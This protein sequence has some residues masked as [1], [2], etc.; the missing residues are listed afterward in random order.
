M[1]RSRAT[2]VLGACALGGA[3]AL[4]LNIN[5]HPPIADAAETPGLLELAASLAAMA[6]P[7]VALST[8][9]IAWHGVA[10][11][12]A[13]ML[14]ALAVWRFSRSLP[15][16]AAMGVVAAASPL[17]F[18]SLA[19]PDVM[20]IA[21][22]AATACAIL[23][24]GII[25]PIAG[26]MAVGAIAPSLI[27]PNAI[28]CWW[29]TRRTAGR[30]RE[31][32]SFAAGSACF[33]AGSA[34]V[35]ANPSLPGQ[36][37]TLAGLRVMMPSGALAA[38]ALSLTTSVVVGMGP[39]A[40]ALAALGLFVS[41]SEA[42]QSAAPDRTR[43]A[44]PTIGFLAGACAAALG[45][46]ADPIRTFAPFVVAAWILMGRGLAEILR[47]SAG[48]WRSVGGIAIAAI[49]V[50]INVSPRVHR[51]P[52]ASDAPVPLGHDTLT[53]R[54][55][56]ELLYQLPPGSAL[57]S[58][59]AISDILLRSLST[60]LRRSRN[61]ISVVPRTS[62]AVGIARANERVFALPRAQTELQQR[63]VRFVEGLV[64][65]VPGVAEVAALAPCDLL[66][67]TWQTLAAAA[68][69][70]RLAI[71]AGN[72]DAR[73]PVVIFTGGPRAID[74]TA[75]GWPALALRGF[76]TRSYDRARPE[77]KQGLLDELI[78]DGAPADLEAVNADYVARTELWR[79]PGAPRALTF[80][81]SAPA[82]SVLA[83]QLSRGTGPIE[84][85]PVFPYAVSAFRK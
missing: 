23:G 63:G 60:S 33:I 52:T 16:A 64:P 69:V 19:P 10:V 22:A 41:I 82:A 8:M 47:R 29:I 20:A 35:L 30:G 48:R 31:L 54:H 26:L 77:R 70:T 73:G 44:V 51:A 34:V 53:R 50:G 32:K 15:A 39:L 42:R 79:V 56:Q 28:L 57:V 80:E 11:F 3:A 18:P 12:A 81:L 24:S 49:L 68:G 21:A 76:Y 58:E 40:L 37:A 4:W 75:I 65:S 59:D 62:D 2:A 46:G 17:M 71:V 83:S 38:H 5:S 1:T 55:F 7:T 27:L 13:A 14:S 9:L 61:G 45:P 74:A 36:S 25:G 43:W 85:C 6:R 72:D 66:T 84:I 67:T 78:Y